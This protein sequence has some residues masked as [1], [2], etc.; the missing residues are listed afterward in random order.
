LNKENH[1]KISVISIALLSAAIL[2]ISCISNAVFLSC[3]QAFMQLYCSAVRKS[4]IAFNMNKNK[5]PPESN[6]ESYGCKN[7]WTDSEGSDTIVPMA[8]SCS[9]CHSQ[10]SSEFI[11][12]WTCLNILR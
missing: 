7:H 3:Q 1:S 6:A 10:S 4:W 12:F 2:S 5:H 8:E 9:N 11:N